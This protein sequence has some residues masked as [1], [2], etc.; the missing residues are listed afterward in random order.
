MMLPYK[1]LLHIA[2]L[3]KDM[4]KNYPKDFYPDIYMNSLED[5]YLHIYHKD[6][7]G[8]LI[9]CDTSTRV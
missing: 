7:T 3:L 9:D 6:L 8:F 2:K 5:A 1:E 4:I